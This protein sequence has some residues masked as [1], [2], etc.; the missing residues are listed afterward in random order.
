MK[1]QPD[2]PAGI[3]RKWAWHYRTLLGLRDRLQADRSELA[4]EA[5]APMEIQDTRSAEGA[6]DESDRDMAFALL[7]SEEN[8][9]AEVEAAIG[10][11]GKGVYGRCESSG[12]PI[13]AAR[14]RA[15]PW[16]RTTVEEE[17]RREHAAVRP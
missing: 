13:P 6:T 10:R 3:D 12:K 11:L 1:P 9:L 17:N 15:I 7:Q 4:A 5:A 14:L 8:A 16:C 2:T